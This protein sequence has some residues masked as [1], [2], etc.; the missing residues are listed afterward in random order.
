MLVCATTSASNTISYVSG[1]S[2]AIKTC[3]Q[4]TVQPV[5]LKVNP[6][7]LQSKMW[8]RNKLRPKTLSLCSL[9]NPKHHKKTKKSDDKQ[10]T[11]GA[12]GKLK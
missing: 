11:D 8:L 5:Y 6:F 3:Q 1:I 4:S 2:Q 10:K 9:T 12:C 7:C